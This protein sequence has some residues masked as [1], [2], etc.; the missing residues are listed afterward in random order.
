MTGLEF[1]LSCLPRASSTWRCSSSSALC[2]GYRRRCVGVGAALQRLKRRH[3]LRG[4]RP[5]RDVLGQ[6]GLDQRDRRLAALRIDLNAPAAT[7]S[8]AITPSANLLHVHVLE[9]PGRQQ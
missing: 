9:K 1:M 3:Q 5:L 4:S 6:A 7:S 8:T 2:R